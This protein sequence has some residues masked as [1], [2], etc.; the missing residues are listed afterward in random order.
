MRDLVLDF[1][2]MRTLWGLLKIIKT[3]DGYSYAFIH[4]LA[5]VNVTNNRE[6][7]KKLKNNLK[8]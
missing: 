1:D 4:C 3:R 5:T 2:N 6:K 8:N 7:Q